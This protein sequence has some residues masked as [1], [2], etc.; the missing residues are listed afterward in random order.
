MDELSEALHLYPA[1]TLTADSKPEEF[2][3]HE[4]EADIKSNKYKRSHQF[5]DFSDGDGDYQRFYTLLTE[6]VNVMQKDRNSMSFSVYF[7]EKLFNVSDF[8]ELAERIF[9]IFRDQS[10]L[11]KLKTTLQE[12]PIYGKIASACKKTGKYG[13]CEKAIFLLQ[14]G[15]RSILA[16]TEDCLCGLFILKL[17]LFYVELLQPFY[18]LVNEHILKGMVARQVIWF[19]NPSFARLLFRKKFF[20]AVRHIHWIYRDQPQEKAVIVSL[21][22][23]YHEVKTNNEKNL[24]VCVTHFYIYT[25]FC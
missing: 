5:T 13:A 18:F 24:L 3:A 1:Q 11:M 10:S 2:M 14:M 23:L 16:V 20:T 8:S 21:V 6:R 7:F 17:W 12:Q 22:R 9:I 4:F 15:A 25:V 19:D